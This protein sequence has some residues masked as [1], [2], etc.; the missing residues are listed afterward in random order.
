MMDK[1][2]KTQ[3]FW[4]LNLENL[5]DFVTTKLPPLVQTQVLRGG[6]SLVL[7]LRKE[8]VATAVGP[9]NEERYLEANN[10]QILMLKATAYLTL[11]EDSS[12]RPLEVSVSVERKG[13]DDVV[14]VTPQEKT[15]SVSDQKTSSSSSAKSSQNKSKKKKNKNPK[16]KKALTDMGLKPDE[17]VSDEEEEEEESEEEKGKKHETRKKSSKRR[18]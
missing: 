8:D 15:K 2:D 5:R 3:L 7:S 14:T 13:G 6:D 18:N 9:L 16:K 11:R 12:K 17:D 10:G 4:T 1:K